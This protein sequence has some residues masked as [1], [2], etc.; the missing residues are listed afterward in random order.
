MT[1][2]L[3][4]ITLFYYFQGICHLYFF[5]SYTIYLSLMKNTL[6]GQIFLKIKKS[7]SEYFSLLSNI[8]HFSVF[9]FIFPFYFYNYLS[10]SFLLHVLFSQILFYTSLFT[11]MESSLKESLPH[12]SFC[13][14]RHSDAKCHLF[15][16]QLSRL[17]FL[18]YDYNQL[19]FSLLLN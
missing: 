15:T 14:K 3:S 16:N 17:S 7:T 19:F 8:L 1:F 12:I 11:F 4:S 10:Y 9:L 6:L 18:Y 13:I 5:F 2:F